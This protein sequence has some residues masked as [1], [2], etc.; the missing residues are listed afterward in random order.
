MIIATMSFRGQND[1]SAIL[2]C[3]H[4][5]QEQKIGDGFNAHF[6]NYLSAVKCDTCGRDGKD[7]PHPSQ[8]QS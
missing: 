6:V 4:C 1:Y 2:L 5:K 7:T 8:E 3:T